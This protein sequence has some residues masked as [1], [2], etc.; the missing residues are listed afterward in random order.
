LLTK[1][2]TSINFVGGEPLGL[3]WI[4]QDGDGGAIDPYRPVETLKQAMNRKLEEYATP[5]KRG[6]LNARGLIELDLL[7]HGG[8]NFFAYNTSSGHLTFEDIA[9]YGADY[10]A[11]HSQRQV[12]DRVWFFH[13]LD[14][15][16]DWNQLVGFA[17]GEGRVRWLTQ[18]WPT[19]VVYR[20]SIAA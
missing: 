8:F 15:A 11:V 4:H 6:H 9:R 12:F 14:S 13:A 7:A 1:Y 2:F 18:R 10:Y 5:E 17:P 19:L 20:G 16:D 3:C